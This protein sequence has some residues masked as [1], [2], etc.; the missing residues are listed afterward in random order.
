MENIYYR[1]LNTDLELNGPILSFLENPVG[2]GSTVT[3]SVTLSGIATV[4]WA[5]TSPSPIGNIKYQWYEVN[6]GVL[7]DGT[8]ITGSATTTLTISNLISPDDS[9]REFYVEADYVPTDEYDSA[10]KGTGNATNEP[11]NSGIATITVDP[12]IEII[13]E[14]STTESV[15]NQS[16]TFS[17]NAGLTDS[18]YGDVNYQW[19]L[20]GNEVSDGTVTD[21]IGTTAFQEGN[22][23]FNYDSDA[24]LNVIDAR[25]I[26]ITIAGGAGGGGASGNAG[27]FGRAGRLPYAPGQTDVSRTLK[28]EV[29]RRGNGGSGVN[30][31]SGG[32]SSYASGG[33]GGPG[34]GGGGG[35]GGGATAVYDETLGRY[36]I[37]SAGGGGGGGSNTGGPPNA[38][39]GGL[40]FGRSRDV[41][42]NSTS[43]PDP[44]NTGVNRGG[45]GGG[46]AQPSNYPASGA[47]GNASDGNGGASGFDT[48]TA[49]FAY[50]GWG[51]SGNGYVNISYVGKVAVDTTIT[52]NTI[53][54][55][56]NSSVL[57]LSTNQVGIQTVSCIVSSPVATNTPGISTTASL[58]VR[59][60]AEEYLL[61]IEGING[62][63]TANLSVIDLF[64]GEYE[65]TTF[66]GDPTLGSFNSL[67]SFYCPD[68]DIDIEMDL[69]G[70]KGSDSGSNTG[71]EGGFSRIRLTLEQNVEYAIAGLIG[72]INAPFFYRKASLIACV[73]GGGKAGPNGN[74]GTGG[75][76]SISGQRGFGIG[77][78]T[79]GASTSLSTNGVFGSLTSLTAESPD[80]KAAIPNGGR[81]LSCTKGV[82]WKNQGISACGDVGTTQFRISDGTV[83][84]NTA[85]I[86][87]GYKDGYNIIQTA[88]GSSQFPGSG[89]AG[90]AGGGGGTN[91]SGGGGAS[92]YSDGSATL[93]DTQSGG[94]SG[95]ARV[96]IRIADPRLYVPIGS[97]SHTFNNA[98]NTN[99]NFQFTGAI[100]D[101]VSASPGAPDQSVDRSTNQKHYVITMNSPYSD[102]V[103]SDVSIQT[104]GGGIGNCSLVKQERVPGST[105]QWRLWFQKSNGFTT[106]VRGFTVTGIA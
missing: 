85:N 93:V 25:D 92:G 82:Y 97:L 46:G 3:G 86:E 104:A 18:S 77:G 103:V 62:T 54:S 72:S 65:F 88:G 21:I 69:Y 8:N 31:G 51:V 15:I 68:R 6:V 52:R 17:I 39:G 7:S 30:G 61:N 19:T 41:M 67:Y 34:G 105:T 38:R 75:G 76:I 13:A 47:G 36:T 27:H 28:F 99:T 56:S 22:Q 106:Y 43:S 42:S 71:G 33:S 66:T 26:T 81:T 87:R 79:G 9:G 84:T 16:S 5:S 45:G 73:G 32:T 55:G 2:V 14:P 57:T 10:L 90:A 59:E 50:D 70:G 35:G 29:G 4:S 58:V 101:A 78:G 12:L 48:R 95:N 80:T 44:G 24:T 94:S 60:N 37:V 63:D 96:I 11:F 74:G 89:G 91:N 1:G 20:N 100:I 49:D 98:S 53:V 64:N 23:S 40:G 83:V 102:I